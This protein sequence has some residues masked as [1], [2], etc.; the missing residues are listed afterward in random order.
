MAS[1]RGI[2]VNPEK[3]K[4]VEEIKAPRCHKE[5]ET[6]NDRFTTRMYIYNYAKNSLPNFHLPSLT[7]SN[8]LSLV[9]IGPVD[10]GHSNGKLPPLKGVSPLIHQ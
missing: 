8:R 4:A 2:E 10:K 6:L 9:G 7:Y 5:F 1:D 3:L